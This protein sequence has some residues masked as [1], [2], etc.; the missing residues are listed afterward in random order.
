MVSS[1]RRHPIVTILIEHS[2]VLLRPL[3][4]EITILSRRR[5]DVFLNLETTETLVVV[6]CVRSPVVDPVI[7]CL[8]K[9]ESTNVY[10]ALHLLSGSRPS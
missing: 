6:K 5:M 3:H 7:F 2:L 8:T 1:P 4:T 9:R 10:L